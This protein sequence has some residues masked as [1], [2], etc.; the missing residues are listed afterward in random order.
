MIWV[1]EKASGCLFFKGSSLARES[2][3]FCTNVAAVWTVFQ[4]IALNHLVRAD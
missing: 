4:E 1:C 2:L 3:K